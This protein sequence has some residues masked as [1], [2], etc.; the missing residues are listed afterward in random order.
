MKIVDLMAEKCNT[1]PI[2]NSISNDN[3]CVLQSESQH[4]NWRYAIYWWSEVMN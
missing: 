4:W 1:F 2:Q 3:F